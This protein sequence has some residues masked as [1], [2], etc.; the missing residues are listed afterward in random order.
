MTSGFNPSRIVKDL[1]VSRQYLRLG[2]T[3]NTKENNNQEKSLFF[4]RGMTAV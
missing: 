3:P 1:F 4:Y 2:D